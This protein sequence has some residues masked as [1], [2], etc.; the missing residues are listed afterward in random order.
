MST[1]N[2]RPASGPPDPAPIPERLAAAYKQLAATADALAEASDQFH[3]PIRQVEAL[4]QELNIGLDTWVSV[5]RQE[6]PE[7]G[8]F[9][10]REVGYIRRSDGWK[11]CFRETYGFDWAPEDSRT[12][13]FNDAPRSLRI[14][15]FDKVP[16]L[17]EKLN[18]NARKTTKKL[19]EKTLEAK[20]LT[21]ILKQ[22]SDEVKAQKQN[23]KQQQKERR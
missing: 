9:L 1:G 15:A 7:Y 10:H 20:A 18:E 19:H 21:S 17:L 6:D 13:D 16:E 8:S 14:E 4:L 12:W 3:K 23:A 2:D 22:A 11:L 5:S